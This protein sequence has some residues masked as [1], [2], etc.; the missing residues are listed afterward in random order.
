MLQIQLVVTGPNIIFA[1]I[2]KLSR[3]SFNPFFFNTTVF[4]F[5]LEHIDN[6][7]LFLNLDRLS[8]P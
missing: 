5:F 6:L 7:P 8:Y 4:H 3:F 1:F 2:K